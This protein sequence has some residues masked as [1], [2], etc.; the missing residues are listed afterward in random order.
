MLVVGAGETTTLFLALLQTPLDL[1]HTTI[2]Q[3]WVGIARIE[4]M[5]TIRQVDNNNHRVVHPSTSVPTMAP[6]KEKHTP[7]EIMATKGPVRILLLNREITKRWE[8]VA[9]AAAWAEDVDV[10]CPHG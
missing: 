7:T 5:R 10:L 3:M 2:K 8:E 1:L 4:E 9:V 6:R